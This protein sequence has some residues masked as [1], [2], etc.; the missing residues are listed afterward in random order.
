MA[1]QNEI[2]QQN[3]WYET[4]HVLYSLYWIKHENLQEGIWNILQHT[5][6]PLYRG[7]STG[8]FEIGG[9][10]LPVGLK[11]LV[12]YYNSVLS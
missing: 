8:A 6:Q 1:I 7:T 9:L 12:N 4:I 3:V 5:A 11:L 2:Q 10:K